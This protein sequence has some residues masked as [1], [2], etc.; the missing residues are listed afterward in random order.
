M[1]RIILA[2]PAAAL[3]V[4]L[5]ACGS[6]RP[7]AT[8]TLAGPG[9]PTPYALAQDAPAYSG[10][11]EDVTGLSIQPAD[12]TVATTRALAAPPASTFP[13]WDGHSVMLYDLR[14]GKA[15]NLGDGA[16]GFGM[17]FSSDGTH[18]TW[19]VGPDAGTN[20]VANSQ[21][22]VL[23]LATMRRTSY[24]DAAA[25]SFGPGGT[26]RLATLAAG[27]LAQHDV[28][29]A[30][31]K[32]AADEPATDA[33]RTHY[34][35]GFVLAR[36]AAS[37][38]APLLYTW[39]LVPDEGSPAL[40]FDA[41]L[42]FAID[43]RPSVLAVLRNSSGTA[44]VYRIDA[45]ATAAIFVATVHAPPRAMPPVVALDDGRIAIGDRAAC[46]DAAARVLLYDPAAGTLDALTTALAPSPA[47]VPGLALGGNLGAARAVLDPSTLQYTTV[48]PA[49][50]FFSRDG[51]WA[52]VGNSVAMSTDACA[53]IGG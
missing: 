21:V 52:V 35:A 36:G 53:S 6:G 25:A 39:Q 37:K 43:G 40:A 14:T 48:L 22:W 13:A 33:M 15:T 24:G 16:I 12:T 7:S 3:V 28:S 9:T 50:G 4:L 18:L 46:A 26:L 30:T 19:Q 1:R 20:K 45:G 29:L 2:A 10:P 47:G 8:A 27:K 41:S 32:A 49:P 34:P 17:P 31:G 44:N 23:D 5:A 51:H 42:V 11:V 38:K